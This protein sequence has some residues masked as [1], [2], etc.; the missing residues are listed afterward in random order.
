MLVGGVIDL[1][2][3]FMANSNQAPRDVCAGNGARV[4]V[5]FWPPVT[6]GVHCNA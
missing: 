5:C 2:G 6:D 1:K 4:C 3:K